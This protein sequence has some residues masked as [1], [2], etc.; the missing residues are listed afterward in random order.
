LYSLYILLALFI[1]LTLHYIFFTIHDKCNY[2]FQMH[3]HGVTLELFNRMSQLKRHLVSFINNI[4]CNCALLSMLEVLRKMVHDRH[5]L[6]IEAQLLLTVFSRIY[7][8]M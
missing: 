1:R 8:A 7:C 4:L 3:E 2:N 5:T 6:V